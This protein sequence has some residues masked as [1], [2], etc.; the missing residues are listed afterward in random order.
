MVSS[1]QPTL[2]YADAGANVPPTVISR[3]FGGLTSASDGVVNVSA[4]GH[5]RLLKNRD[6]RVHGSVGTNQSPV[7]SQDVVFNK[8]DLLTWSLGERLVGQVHLCG[9]I[10]PP[11]GHRERHHR[12]QS[13]ETAREV[14]TAMSVSMSGFI[15]SLAYQF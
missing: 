7:G 9:G 2:I 14:H 13:A 11:V 15:Y 6:L 1:D 4:G 10:Q 5:V 8:V 3:P 12:S